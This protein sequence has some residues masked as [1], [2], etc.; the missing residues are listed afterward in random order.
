MSFIFSTTARVFIFRFVHVFAS[1]YYYAFA[2]ASNLLKVAIQLAAFMVAGQSW[3][4]VME[5]GLPYL[6]RRW[7]Q[8]TRRR[9]MVRQYSAATKVTVKQSP[10]LGSLDHDPDPI[11]KGDDIGSIHS[12]SRLAQ[13]TAMAWEEAM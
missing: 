3:N 11:P 13:A 6:K 7:L 9:D 8:I 5:T 10:A 2:D 12:S 1:L 4:N